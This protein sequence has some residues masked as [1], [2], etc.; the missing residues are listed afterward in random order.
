MLLEQVQGLAV[1]LGIGLLIGVERERRKGEGAARAMAGVRSFALLGLLGGLSVLLD[2]LV[3]LLVLFGVGLLVAVSYWRSADHDPG[4]TTEIA[5]L[6]TVLLGALAMQQ[7]A[8]SAGLGVLVAMLLMAKASIHRFSRELIS[9]DE[10]RDGLLL[11]AAAMVILPLLPDRPVGPFGVFNPWRLWLLVVLAMAIGALGHILL[12]LV[13][14]RWGMALAGFFAGYVSSTAATAEFGRRA[15]AEPARLRSSVAAAMMASAASLTLF[16]PLL[17][18]AAPDFLRHIAWPLGA[19][20]A[21]TVL[22]GLLGLRAGLEDGESST[23]S[24]RMFRFG[25]ALAFA[26]AVAALL[27]LSAALNA[28][29]GPR[30]V[31]VGTTIAALAEAHASALSLGQLDAS[32]ALPRATAVL[33]FLGILFASSLS[34]T[35][36]AFVAGGRAYALRV[37][38]GLLA[39][40]SA[41]ALAV[42]VGNG[43]AAG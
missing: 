25:D 2:P 43:L 30:A 37:G 24:R 10:L 38:A 39:M 3:L 31:L 42:W 18:A 28:W 21:V 5:A 26:A 23:A 7:T 8:M 11:A 4:I 16:F 6:V 34:K 27:L 40:S 36:I 17:A 22:G 9:E 1:A 32:G 35:L 33:G 29:L 19:A 41:A 20:L 14:G 15:R 13:G 12:R